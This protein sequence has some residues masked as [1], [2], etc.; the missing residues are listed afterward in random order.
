MR[1]RVPLV[2]SCAA[3]LVAVLG[4]TSPGQAAVR[5]LE[6]SVPF[7]KTSGYAAAAGN[8]AK[9]N[10]HA[11]ST[12]GKAGTIP[13]VGKNGKLPTSLGAVGPQGPAGPAGTGTQVDLSKLLSNNVDVV[14]KSLV[15]N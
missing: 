9:L 2:I 13:V 11:S 8:A 15:M 14:A 12:S 1:Q 5:G 6:A 10:G 4:A 7:A 3:L